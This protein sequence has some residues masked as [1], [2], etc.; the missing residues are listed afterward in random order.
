LSGAPPDR[1][2]PRS[3]G[4]QAPGLLGYADVEV[5]ARERLFRGYFAID[6]YRLRHRLHQG[7]WSETVA[8]EIFERGQA[9]AVVLYDPDRDAL[10]LIE[11]FRPGVL[12]AADTGQVRDRG[13]PWLIEIVAGI[14]GPGETADEV[15]RRE[16]MEEAG[17]RVDE[18][19]FLWRIFASPGASS[20]TISL[21]FARTRAPDPGA[22]HGLAH[23][24]EDIRLLVERPEQVY[25]W[26]DEGR[27]VNGPALLGL[28]WFRLHEQRLRY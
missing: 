17:C 3:V 16:A 1:L 12:A 5:Q 20:E 15:A 19:E 26:I 11:Q 21:F 13:G 9:A 7:G 4:E 8:R 10:V 14:I 6:R 22:V 27:I 23:A 2:R 24:H 28:L 18:I 25:R